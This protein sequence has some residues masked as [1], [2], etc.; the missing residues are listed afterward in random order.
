MIFLLAVVLCVVAFCAYNIQMGSRNLRRTLERRQVLIWQ[1]PEIFTTYDGAKDD[2]AWLLRHLALANACP[3][4]YTLSADQGVPVLTKTQRAI[5]S[6]PATP[7]Q[8]GWAHLDT[9]SQAI[10]AWPGAIT[11]ADRAA[12]KTLLVHCNH[13]A[14]CYGGEVEHSACTSC[15]AR[16]GQ[17]SRSCTCEGCKP[18]S[19]RISALRARV[20]E[21]G[22]VAQQLDESL[23]YA[24]P[25]VRT[26]RSAP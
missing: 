16:A 4:G 15:K 23:E 24:S 14:G 13:C 11:A 19:G 17:H 2:Y 6:T 21:Y 8:M 12:G 10:H 1:V 26:F 25:R 7:L 22:S 9:Y 5:T 20:E 18:T 3:P